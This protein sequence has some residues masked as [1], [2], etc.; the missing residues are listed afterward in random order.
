MY[1]HWFTFQLL[2][3]AGG[4][5]LL[6]WRGLRLGPRA[7][8]ARGWLIPAVLLALPVASWLA[9]DQHRRSTDGELRREVLHQALAVAHALD[10]ALVQRLDFTLEDRSRPGFAVLRG[11]LAAYARA[12]GHRSLYTMALRSEGIVFGPE[13]L[14]DS[15]PMASPP[16]TAYEQPR[17][18]DWEC[19]RAGV[20]A[21]FGPFS[22]EYGTFV[23]GLAPVI[24]ARTGRVLAAV[25]LD[26]P[27]Q[28]WEKIVARARAEP[29]RFTVALTF[30]V[31]LGAALLDWRD[32]ESSRR[33]GL[34]RH[35]EAGLT[36]LCGLVAFGVLAVWMHDSESLAHRQALRQLAE[37]RSE[38]VRQ[39]LE[40]LGTDAPRRPERI[41]S[42]ALV[43]SGVGRSLVESDLFELDPAATPRWLT[44]HPATHPPAA[45][46]PPAWSLTQTL[47]SADL[48]QPVFAFG[49]AYALVLRPGEA[50][51]AAYPKRAGK[52]VIASGCLLSIAAA[53][54]VGFMHRREEKLDQLLADRARQLEAQ[55][56]DLKRHAAEAE[57]SR[58]A[59]LAHLAE[60]ER[61]RQVADEAQRNAEE[62]NDALES[63]IARA[64][65]MALEAELAN[66]AKSQFLAN[67]SHEIRTP[68]NGIIGMTGLLLDTPL[69]AEQRRYTDIVRSSAESLLSL[70][71]DILDFSKIEARK[72]ELEESDFDL[73]ATVE[74]AV[75]LLA[76]KAQEKDL[77]LTY[78]IEPGLPEHLRGDS[79]R[80]RQILLNLA[81]N[82]IK[83]TPRGEV[84]I[85][86]SVASRT[87]DRTTLRFEV[88]DT[89][90]GIA[91]EHL[92]RLFRAFTQVDS[93]TTRQYG[94][95]GLGL[96]ISKQLVELMGGQI[97]VT[98]DP[99]R[100]STFW[101]TAVLAPAH[102][103]PAPATPADTNADLTGLHALVVDDHENNRLLVTS[104]LRRWGCR[105]AE[106]A[107][108][109]IALIHLESARLRDPFHVVLMDRQMP[110][111]DG[112]ELARRIKADPNLRD[113]PLVLL[114]S[115]VLPGD[116]TRLQQAGFTACLPK[117]IRRGQLRQCLERLARPP[118]S[119]PAAGA[120]PAPSAVTRRPVLTRPERHLLLAE[121][122]P[123]N[124]AVG[125]AILKRLGYRADVAADGR[126]VLHLMGQI[127]YDLVLMDCQM[128]GMDGFEATRR[129]RAGSDG[130]LNPRV[131]IIAMTANA[132]QGDRERCLEAGMDDYVPK[133]IRRDELAETLERWLSRPTLTAPA[134]ADP[135]GAEST[136][137]PP[138][139][140]DTDVFEESEFLARTM[141]DRELAR[142]IMRQ[143][144]DD[145][146]LQLQRLEAALNA[147][148]IPA[149]RR[150]AHSLKGA[151]GT[152]G[153][154]AL[155]AAAFD[156]E[157]AI[158]AG[159]T[160][161]A[162]RELPRLEE[163]T[164]RFLGLLE[165]HNWIAERPAATLAPA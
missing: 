19:L 45:A 129:I 59:A 151:A 63:A 117:P 13:S 92:D 17:P 130:V 148:D 159:R 125:L 100:G 104:L 135:I 113:L 82:A 162:L 2:L 108:G 139:L 72:V 124:Q 20:A 163:E 120:G 88:R 78:L 23:S 138:S 134:E 65:S 8:N 149:A 74:E 111:M 25:G 41:L 47:T 27:A 105:F 60:A 81:G 145:I 112:D 161:Q 15:D 150:H 77:E 121:D 126:E 144:V 97:G 24:E 157:G 143:F 155:S 140:I 67:M 50:F 102:A 128:P 84:S 4:I 80:L 1:V 91:P 85:R 35:A 71:N 147:G 34:L 90:I 119:T 9:A 122:N 96:A 132:M 146:P 99:G 89:G 136:S 127:P 142:D 26:V 115:L 7:G 66:V 57:A 56:A 93:S 156:V 33:R 165:E 133:P 76:V 153:A 83:F 54:V 40:A 123:T 38:I 64:N 98:S 39:R 131:A 69:N 164:E 94:G 5:A 110:G 79:G 86:L 52:L 61:A 48:L 95:T 152:V 62:T 16:G 32:R 46:S 30:L 37:A 114:S 106:A 55:S 42:S 36:A 116:T 73:I 160:A 3:S 51:L 44:S 137:P 107:D 53:L 28:D 75:E 11:Q 141:D 87:G 18:E 21:V 49:R 10:P 31:L 29:V 158:A 6:A 12:A 43:R 109:R 154:R 103:S 68:M 101:F 70:I 22:D 118:H 14:A 58:N